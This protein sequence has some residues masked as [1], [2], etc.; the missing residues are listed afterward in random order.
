MKEIYVLTTFLLKS[1]LREAKND[2]SSFVNNIFNILLAL[3]IIGSVIFSSYKIYSI[4]NSLQV[5]Y[6]LIPMILTLASVGC[7]ILGIYLV[8]S[9]FCFAG[10]NEFL[11]SLPLNDNKLF[12]SKIL[13]VYITL[14]PVAVLFILA[15]FTYGILAKESIVFYVYSL[16]SLLVIPI[17]PILYGVIVSLI[18]A[19]LTIGSKNKEVFQNIFTII[20]I[21][22]MM[23]LVYLIIK[24]TISPQFIQGVT[25]NIAGNKLNIINI[26]FPANILISKAIIFNKDII[27]LKS[28]IVSI[29]FSIVI[30]AIIL[31]IGKKV[32]FKILLNSSNI[33]KSSRKLNKISYKDNTSILKTLIKREFSLLLKNNQFFLYTIGILPI[34]I[35]ILITLVPIANSMQILDKLN[36]N[37]FMLYGLALYMPTLFAGYNLT[38]ATSFSREGRYLELLLQ[39]PI[40]YKTIFLSKLIV[41]L[42]L[43]GM[44]VPITLVM[45]LVLKVP[46]SIFLLISL[47]IIVFTVFIIIMSMIEDITHLNLKWT[48]EKELFKNNYRLFKAMIYPIVYQIVMVI[49]NLILVKVVDDKTVVF[50]LISSL[51]IVIGIVLII[52]SYKKLLLKLNLLQSI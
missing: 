39:M 42:I 12:L 13:F 43:N 1:S 10:D 33:E 15:L 6:V 30:F 52:K 2:K 37:Y 51:S 17:L 45:L 19:K 16:I 47:S 18:L 14:L 24:T 9:N 8:L 49:I 46:I 36:E 26:L 35:F 25:N 28:I 3:I 50:Y 34:F 22:I 20:S 27:G 5:G 38:A 48:Y 23:V 32:Y 7:T 31:T 21:V 11:L 29:I 40:S 4:L 41:A 44:M